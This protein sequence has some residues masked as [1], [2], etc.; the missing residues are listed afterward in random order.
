MFMGIAMHAALAGLVLAAQAA[1]AVPL[2]FTA[3]LPLPLLR[4]RVA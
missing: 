1:T 2:P 3:T 4:P